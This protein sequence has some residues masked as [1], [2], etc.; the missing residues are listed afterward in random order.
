MDIFG[1]YFYVTLNTEQF[2]AGYLEVP[3]FIFQFPV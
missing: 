2:P 3:F 1:E